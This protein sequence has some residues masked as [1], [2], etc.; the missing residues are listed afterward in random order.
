MNLARPNKVKPRMWAPGRVRMGHHLARGLVG[1]WPFWEGPSGST[2]L[3]DASGS[4]NHGVLTNMDPPTDWVNSPY[5]YALDLDGTDDYIRI[6]LTDSLSSVGT[7]PFAVSGWFKTSGAFQE[8]CLINH[9]TNDPSSY[10]GW[11]LWF[12]AVG[13]K[14]RL[15]MDSGVRVT[16]PTVP[17]AGWHH[18]VGQWTGTSAQIWLD[19]VEASAAYAIA[20][21]VSAFD[22]HIGAYYAGGGDT[23]GT[24]DFRHDDAIGSVALWNRSFSAAEIQ[25][26][27]EDPFGLIRPPSAMALFAIGASGGAPPAGITRLVGGR[28]LF[29]L[30]G[31]GGGLAA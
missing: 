22:Y 5:G 13:D 7:G 28:G 9:L 1:Y 11:M 18:V 29:S 20:P 23:G 25:E 21:A 10:S 12:W 14:L 6:P 4:S 24:P 31:N 3:M 19:N 2:R 30:A 26:L 17:S 8:G 27:Y 15:Y 16:H